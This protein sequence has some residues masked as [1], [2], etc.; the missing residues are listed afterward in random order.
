MIG[1]DWSRNA[2]LMSDDPTEITQESELFITSPSVPQHI[3]TGFVM[4]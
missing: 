4:Q 1:V 2:G 3:P